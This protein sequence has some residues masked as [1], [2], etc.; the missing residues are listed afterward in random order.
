[1]SSTSEQTDTVVHPPRNGGL[2]RSEE[3]QRTGPSD[4][5]DESQMHYTR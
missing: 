4:N 2:L 5:V 1:M 3:K